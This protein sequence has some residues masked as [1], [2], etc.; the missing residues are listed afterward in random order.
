MRRL[1]EDLV[2]GGDEAAVGGGVLGLAGEDPDAV[3]VLEG[4]LDAEVAF[5]AAA[6]RVAGQDA[7]E[8]ASCLLVR[9]RDMVVGELPTGHLEL[10]DQTADQVPGIRKGRTDA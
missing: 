2:P 8:L 5:D 4:E 7:Q 1:V 9:R 10:G 6:H 3:T